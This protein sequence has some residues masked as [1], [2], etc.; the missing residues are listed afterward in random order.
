MEQC[1]EPWPDTQSE[2]GLPDLPTYSLPLWNQISI[3][4]IVVCKVWEAQHQNGLEEK[5]HYS[6][7]SFITQNTIFIFGKQ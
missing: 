1:Q 2:R 4:N 3:Q 6:A 7:C 5:D